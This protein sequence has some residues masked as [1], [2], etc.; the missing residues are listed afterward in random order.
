MSCR[1]QVAHQPISKTGE[2]CACVN[3]GCLTGARCRYVTLEKRERQTLEMNAK[4]SCS[5]KDTNIST[6][7]NDSQFWDP[8]SFELSDKQVGP[9]ENTVAIDDSFVWPQPREMDSYFE[10]DMLWYTGTPSVAP[11]S[12]D[13]FG[14]NS[15]WYSD[16]ISVATSN[17]C[18][19]EPWD[20]P[21]LPI[22]HYVPDTDNMLDFQTQTAVA[23]SNTANT[24]IALEN[25][26]PDMFNK[27]L[28]MLLESN[29]AV[30]IRLLDNATVDSCQ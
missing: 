24:S 21:S 28:S 26:D 22:D 23:D 7:S 18:P 27:V 3:L 8:I 15:P 14:S 19:D 12:V 25:L 2:S 4:A 11:S 9:T 20:P 30:K 17:S 6:S 13:T 10:R 1:S 16:M 29:N 5:D